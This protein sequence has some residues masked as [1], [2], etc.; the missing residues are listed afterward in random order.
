MDVLR[1]A[2]QRRG[3]LN[4]FAPVLERAEGLERERRTLIQATEER[5][6][7]RNASSQEV[8]TR[9]RNKEDATDLI[10]RG[11]ELGEEISRLEKE[12]GDVEQELQRILLEIP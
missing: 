10:T 2:L 12:L 1:D 3:A 11:R 9:K 5:K 4:A 8:A 6:A 7:A